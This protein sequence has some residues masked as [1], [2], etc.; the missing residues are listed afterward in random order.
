MEEEQQ[1]QTEEKKTKYRVIRLTH[2]QLNMLFTYGKPVRKRDCLPQPPA[3][4]PEDFKGGYV[5]WYLPEDDIVEETR[6]N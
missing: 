3:P 6:I 4:V 5:D 1:Q 2:H